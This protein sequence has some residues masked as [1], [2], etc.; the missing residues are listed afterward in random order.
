MIFS[1]SLRNITVFPIRTWATIINALTKERI[2]KGA[3]EGVYEDLVWKTVSDRGESAV[4]NT[5]AV[6]EGTSKGQ[7]GLV[8][9]KALAK[10]IGYPVQP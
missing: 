3:K 5:S 7:G 9:I 1:L 8:Y 10:P 2:A 4:E 6:E